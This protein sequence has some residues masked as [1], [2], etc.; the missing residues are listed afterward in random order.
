M[1]RLSRDFGLNGTQRGNWQQMTRQ[2][3][4]HRS[5]LLSRIQDLGDQWDLDEVF[6]AVGEGDTFNATVDLGRPTRRR[7]SKSRDRW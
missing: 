2:Q 7:S 1:D 5:G 4:S 6:G 3:G